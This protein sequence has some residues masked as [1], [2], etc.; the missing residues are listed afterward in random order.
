MFDLETWG[1]DRGWGVTLV[2]SLMI[3]GDGPTQ[4]YTYDLT[5]T[6]K[7]PDK[8]SD[9][10]ELGAILLKHITGCHVAYAHNGKWFDI[11]WLNSVALKYKMPPLHIKLIDPVQVAR[12]KY[13][14]GNNSLGAVA[15]FLGLDESKMP[16]SKEVWRG[17]LL[18]NDK[19]CWAIL[20][21]RC[22]SDVRLLNDVAA[23]ISSDVG[24][25]D[26]SGSAYR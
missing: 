20:R 3:H 8:R 23:R 25:V 10:S 21:E 1:L 16:V 18:D 6:S 4:F 17:A 19:S 13:R 5:E 9:D 22:E 15:D 7:W 12:N 24:M 11:P 26:Y 14:I 2:G